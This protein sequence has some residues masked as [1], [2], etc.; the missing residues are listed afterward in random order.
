[1]H[2]TVLFIEM[3]KFVKENITI[4]FGSSRVYI[5][6]TSHMHKHYNNI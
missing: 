6:H 5:I 1:M 2:I 3:K 4:A